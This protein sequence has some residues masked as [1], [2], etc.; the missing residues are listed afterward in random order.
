MR[1]T[2]LFIVY[3][4]AE[5]TPY[6]LTFIFDTTNLLKLQNIYKRTDH[7]KVDRFQTTFFKPLK[8]FLSVINYI[9]EHYAK[10]DI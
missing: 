9:I 3:V 4:L 10:F 8:M 2:T 6:F 5:D 7:N 1:K